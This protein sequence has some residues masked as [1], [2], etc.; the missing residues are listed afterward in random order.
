M[1]WLD[2]VVIIFSIYCLFCGWR[3]TEDRVSFLTTMKNNN[4]PF[5]LYLLL[6]IILSG[7]LGVFY[8]VYYFFLT[9]INLLKIFW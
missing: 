4:T 1:E 2:I 8:G 3:F 7:V 6:R 5:I 9:L